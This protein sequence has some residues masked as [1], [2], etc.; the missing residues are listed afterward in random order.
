MIEVQG[1]RSND[2]ETLLRH[3]GARADSVELDVGL[4]EG[5][6][7]VAH[8]ADF[9]D[10][11][12]LTLDRALELAGSTEL[13]VEAKCYPPET[14]QPEEFAEALEPYLDRIRVISFEPWVLREV[15]KRRPEAAIGFLFEEPVEVTAFAPTI[16][17]DR[18]LVTRELVQ[19]AHGLGMR[20]VPW[21]VN[22]PSEMEHLLDLGVDGLV[23]DDV[24]AARLVVAARS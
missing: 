15:R 18:R 24:A 20:V 23:T 12:G 2:E 7:V 4:R 1:H 19:T 6:L 14:P 21:T 13:V 10:A 8:D 5:A 17:P 16:G 3:L 9:A 11:S 22:E